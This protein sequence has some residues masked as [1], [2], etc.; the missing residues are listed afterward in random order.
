MTNTRPR[1]LLW[2]AIALAV[3][4]TASAQ[5]IF[6]SDTF[7]TGVNQTLEAHT[8]D[9]GGAWTRVTGPGIVIA[10]TSDDIRP[11]GDND[12]DVYTNGATP[13]AAEYV[14]GINVL[15]T[16][17]N[18]DNY[19]QIFGRGNIVSG[20]GYLAHVGANGVVTLAVFSGGSPTVLSSTVIPMTLNVTHT[21]VLSIRDSAKQVYVDGVLRASST[22]NA[23][24]AVGLVG[25]AMERNAANQSRGDNFYAA[26]FAPTEATF[27]DGSVVRD[28]RGRAL[29]EWSTS[30]EVENL[31]FRVHRRAAG[32]TECLTP[33]PIAGSAFQAG[34]TVLTAGNDYRWLDADAPADA[35]YWIEAINV[36]Q[37]RQWHGPI[38][39]RAGP[40]EERFALSPSL[41]ELSRNGVAQ[42]A[43]RTATRPAAVAAE[44]ESPAGKRRSATPYRSNLKQLELAAGPAVKI[45]VE[46]EG[47]VRVPRSALLAAGLPA[48]ADPTKLALFADGVEVAILVEDGDVLFY[49]RPLDSAWTLARTYWL[50]AGN[51]I[52]RRVN[53]VSAGSATTEQ[54]SYAATIER[55]DKALFYTTLRR[56]DGDNFVGPVISTDLAKPTLQELVLSAVVPGRDAK[57]DVTIQG[58]TNSTDLLHRVAVSFN[59][60]PLGVVEHAGQERGI[61]TFTVPASALRDGVN[62]VGLVALGGEG[63]VNAVESVR[64]VYERRYRAEDERL[65]MAVEGGRRARLDGFA[66]ASSVRLFDVTDP[67]SPQ[68]LETRT[69]DGALWAVPRGSGTRV[70]V[71][72]SGFASPARVDRNE[73]SQL[74]AAAGAD[75]V[76]VTHPSLAA[77]LEPLRAHRESRGLRVLVASTEDIY[78][79]FS[80][81]AKD[82]FAI[83]ALL[84][85]SQRWNVRPRFVVLAGDASFDS[86]NY[87]GGGDA[88][89]VPTRL[90][91]TS[92]SRTASDSWFTDFDLDG[93]SEIAIGRLPARTPEQ[94]AAIV[95]KIVAYDTAPVTGDWNRQ[96]LLVSD[97]DAEH[98]FGTQSAEIAAAIP[99][100]LTTTIIDAGTAGIASARQQLLQR[101][102]AGALLVYYN[103]HGSVETWGAQRLLTR[104]DALA[105]KNGA[106]LPVVVAMTCLNGYFHDVMT[107][108]LAEAFLRA[109]D[110]GAVAVWTSSALT[111]PIAQ[112]LS[113]DAFTH[114][115]FA[116]PTPTTLG[117]AMLE[118][119]RAATVPDVRRTFLL[120]GDPA[121][122]LRG[123]E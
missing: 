27:F 75:M 109:P 2:I 96:A 15:F 86:R 22:N 63:D 90:V 114:A 52:A 118:A 104:D 119:Q 29:I 57:L 115:L 7:T 97:T 76:I 3:A 4:G 110:G 55:R 37:R 65:L 39:G 60:K 14:V 67:A 56:E 88:D 48:D 103:G 30:R 117:E 87:L 64:L 6:V 73:P 59:G 61:A 13:P 33:T 31:G 12:W 80:F 9:T 47:W 72:Q 36:Q 50:T 95:A 42:T 54:A 45:A 1:F 58:G 62:A 79:E 107:D 94:L 100:T 85:A 24:T 116:S 8:P 82:P 41:T 78:D 92:I 83:R 32:R 81:G 5:T 38:A 10:A 69:E 101:L 89:L 49:G 17:A 19:V 99:G 112:Q 26:T 84:T 123:A 68:E 25:L 120:F 35:T 40:I 16:N 91:A 74:H 53:R 51:G 44:A 106:R 105:A 18:A 20:N 66:A 21:V 98:N 111:D 70:L 93:T 43:M 23:V 46:R 71:A 77:A 113:A 122:T 11:N 34:T 102:D 108:S 28:D 121:T